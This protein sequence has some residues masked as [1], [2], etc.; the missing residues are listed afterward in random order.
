MCCLGYN[1]AMYQSTIKIGHEILVQM[2]FISALLI[3]GVFIGFK[4][5]ASKEL[6]VSDLSMAGKQSVCRPVYSPGL[7][8]KLQPAN[9][10]TH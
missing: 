3:P 5:N 8:I 6:C 4:P 7:C 1:A 2:H 10:A 9:P